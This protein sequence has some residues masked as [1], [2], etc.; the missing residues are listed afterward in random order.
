MKRYYPWLMA[1]LAMLILLVSNGLTIPA[2]TAF[3]TT[4]LDEFGWSRS[5]LKF[6]DLVTLLL[7]GLL[8]PI[9]GIFIDRLGPRRL[10][11]AGLLLLAALYFVYSKITSIQHVY[12]I[13]V[14]F[15]A[16]LVA[17]GLNVAVIMVSQWFIA[18]RGTAIGIAL[19]G[20][21]L[22]G[23]VFP[24]IVVALLPS[25]GWRET[26][27]SLAF[28]P[29]AMFALVLLLARAPGKIPP[30]GAEQGADN[31]KQAVAGPDIGYAAAMRTRTFWALAVIAMTTFYSLMSVMSHLFL[32]MRD[33]Q[34]DLA[35]AG[36]AMAVM[37]GLGMVGK[38]LF[39][40]LADYLSPSFVLRTNIVIMS[41][42][43][44]LLA[45][46]KPGLIWYALVL[47][48]LG[49]G[50]M[51]TMIQLLAVSSFGL[52][53][54][55]KILGTITM[56]DAG[57]AGLGIWFTALLFDRFG[58]YQVAF[59]LICGLMLLALI[60]STQ[61]RSAPRQALATPAAAG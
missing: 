4:L 6:R 60:A 23:M 42:G 3:D 13:H 41:A 47:F 59:N 22:G 25:L 19:L 44:L 28:V 55:G 30:L 11:S 36:Q 61:I 52:S 29:L 37:F 24:K 9:I 26:F 46:L 5:E 7:A 39:G 38:F 57:T 43:A 33:M 21:S 45:T 50:G 48:G 20:T 10:A 17:S 34:F 1:L 2:V 56:L 31:S 12:L 58:N 54:A 15:A 32:H 53:S 49:W 51:Y 27:V 16:V 8:A 18:K 35:T 40:M 14:G